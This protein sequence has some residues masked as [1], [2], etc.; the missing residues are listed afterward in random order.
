MSNEHGT[1]TNAKEF[2]KRL[3]ELAGFDDFRVE[4]DEAHRHGSIFI[5]SD[6]GLIKENLPVI[7]EDLNHVMQ[8]LAR[9]S[10]EQPIFL[11]VNNYRHE[12]EGLIIELTRATARKAVASRAEVP[13]PAMNSYER[14]LAHLELAAHPEVTT[15][16]VG[17]GKSRYVVVKPILEENK[18]SETGQADKAEQAIR[19]AE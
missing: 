2:L 8:L 18:N 17:K 11:D 4:V 7:V 13:L 9:K 6:P 3:L 19:A 1:Q 5:H 10:N 12:R 15:E 14:R 16:S